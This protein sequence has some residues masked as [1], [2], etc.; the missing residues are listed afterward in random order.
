MKC[1]SSMALKLV[2]LIITV[3]MI[4]LQL[5]AYY[6]HWNK[7]LIV[8]FEDI[9]GSQETSNRLLY[10]GRNYNLMVDL[11]ELVLNIHDLRCL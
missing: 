3:F 6:E 4:C 5:Q 1:Y 7:L 9:P 2:K 10:R 8:H 11:E